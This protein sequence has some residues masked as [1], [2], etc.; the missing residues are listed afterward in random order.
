MQKRKTTTSRKAVG[1]NAPPPTGGA[2]PSRASQ[3]PLTANSRSG[4]AR[5]M[6]QRLG[7]IPSIDL[8]DQIRRSQSRATTMHPEMQRLVA[9]GGATFGC[10]RRPWPLA[11]LPVVEVKT[12]S[13]SAGVDIPPLQPQHNRKDHKNKSRHHADNQTITESR[14]PLALLAEVN[15]TYEVI[16]LGLLLGVIDWTGNTDP[17]R[18]FPGT[19]HLEQVAVR[20]ATT[21]WMPSESFRAR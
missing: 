17:G 21:L 6:H 15:I 14:P 12:S 4:S 16:M 9:S 2:D 8:R 5:P 1:D 20:G 19:D 18:P 13:T 3:P 10:I 11:I 7:P